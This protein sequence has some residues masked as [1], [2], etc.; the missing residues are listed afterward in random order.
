MS[1]PPFLSAV[2]GATS[3]TLALIAVYPLDLIKTRLQTTND[4][5]MKTALQYLRKN[6]EFMRL[7]DGMPAALLAQ[8]SNNFAYFYWYCFTL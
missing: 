6:K 1:L 3:S 2:S 5:E 4:P 7:Y 8:A